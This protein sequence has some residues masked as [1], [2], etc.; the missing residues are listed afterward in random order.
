MSLGLAIPSSLGAGVAAAV[1]PE[2]QRLGY[3]SVWSNDGASGPGLPLLAAAQRAAGLP[4]GIGV[5]PC[6]LRSAEQIA[7]AVETL[8]ID[9]RRAVIGLGSGRSEHP[10]PAVRAAVRDLRA[11]LGTDATI[12]IACLGPLMCRLAGEI[13]D[14]ALLNWMTP[15]R[16]G[17]ARKRVEEGER[18]AGRARG[19]VRVSMYVRVALGEDADARLAAEAGRY[20]RLPA[21]HRNF[22][23]MGVDPASVGIASTRGDD[24]RARLEPYQRALDETLVRVMPAGSDAED[25]LVIARAAA[26]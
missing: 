21:Y 20:D 22:E 16:I 4:V 13:A 6:D 8:G 10:V 9:L 2:A 14:V 5:I 3:A 26:P 25:V 11:R 15:A 18:H 24:V 17:W 23:A 19:A 7:E 1:A 12:A